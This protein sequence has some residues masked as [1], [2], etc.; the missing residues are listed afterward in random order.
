MSPVLGWLV[1]E[2][3]RPE[4]LRRFPATYS[5]VVAH[6]V[7]LQSDA[8]S[9]SALP[10]ET[11]AEIV[12]EADDGQGVQALVV[13]IGGTTDRPDGST[14]HITW[15]LDRSRGRKAVESNDVIARHGWIPCDAVPVKLRPA[16]F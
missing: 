10:S 9:D 11:S 5:D 15:S 16:R 3:E 4:L 7:T 14:F 1:D 12:G 6:H 2:D 8:P 13:R